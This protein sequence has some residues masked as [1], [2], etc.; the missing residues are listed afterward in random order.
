MNLSKQLS[1]EILAADGQK[2]G[3]GIIQ[4]TA[5]C[6][7]T[8]RHAFLED[9]T[10]WL[11]ENRELWQSC[12]Q[13][14]PQHEL[15]IGC[16]DP[17]MDGLCDLRFAGLGIREANL[18]KAAQKIIAL[19]QN[20]YRGCEF[21]LVTHDGCKASQRAL[22]DH[23]VGHKDADEFSQLWGRSLVQF[24]QQETGQNGIRHEHVSKMRPEQDGMNIIYVDCTD[25]FRR[26]DTLPHGPTVSLLNPKGIGFRTRVFLESILGNGLQSHLLSD[27][28][29]MVEA[30]S[31]GES[32]KDRFS[33][34]RPLSIVLIRNR[35]ESMLSDTAQR[36]VEE[37]AEH[38][39]GR[40]KILP[41][42]ERGTLHG[43][44][45]KNP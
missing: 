19:Q 25:R 27:V 28:T 32:T 34:K 43:S 36:G 2:A 20:V 8:P 9:P 12:F 17:R 40:I 41:I 37:C 7:T 13:D 38:H 44:L 3:L 14:R 33:E 31:G 6:D 39:F 4:K 29:F 10:Q 22:D 45:T 26:S 1:S 23:G 24:I 16:A 18:E 42:D 15:R 35:R 11:C 30:L 5:A 21:A